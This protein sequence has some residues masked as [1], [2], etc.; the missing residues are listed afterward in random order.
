MSSDDLRTTVRLAMEHIAWLT[1]ELRDA[2]D[3]L[4]EAATKGG[5]PPPEAPPAA[6]AAA[7]GT[8]QKPD[9]L[10]LHGGKAPF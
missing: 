4:G 1:L 3:R 6:V 5:S 9:P 2:R 7:Q 10:F 8:S